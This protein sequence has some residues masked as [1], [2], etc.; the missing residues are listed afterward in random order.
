MLNRRNVI[1]EYDEIRRKNNLKP[2]LLEMYKEDDREKVIL[3]A[4]AEFI[5]RV[6]KDLD[7]M[8]GIDKKE[9]VTAR[10]TKLNGS[11]NK[12]NENPILITLDQIEDQEFDFLDKLKLEIL[13]TIKNLLKGNHK[14]VDR[15]IQTLNTPNGRLMIAVVSAYCLGEALIE[16]F[17]CI[18]ASKRLEVTIKAKKTFE[19]ELREVFRTLE[20]EEAVLYFRSK[21]DT[22]GQYLVGIHEVSKLMEEEYLYQ[23]S[24]RDNVLK[25]LGSISEQVRLEITNQPRLLIEE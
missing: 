3:F 22:Y 21:I 6:W 4:V 18:D 15:T 13:E 9:Q 25:A 20:F 7:K 11:S 12:C 8:L 2:L 17:G 10:M 5:P 19:Q 24:D 16:K 23:I 1:A 14:K